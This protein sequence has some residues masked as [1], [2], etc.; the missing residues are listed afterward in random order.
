[1]S[2][3]DVTPQKPRKKEQ[4]NHPQ[5]REKAPGRP[6]RD[7]GPP[8]AVM[9]TGAGLLLPAIRTQYCF[10]LHAL[11][12]QQFVGE[13]PGGFRIDLAYAAATPSVSVAGSTLKDPLLGYIKD[14]ELL[15]GTDWV[16]VNRE[17]IIDFDSRI[18]LKL[19]TD[20]LPQARRPA[21]PCLISARLRGRGDLRKAENAAHQPLFKANDNATKVISDWRNGFD[22]GST[23][24]LKLAVTAD[25]PLEGFDDNQTRVYEE[26]RPLGASLFLGEATVKF[27]KGTCGAVNGIDLSVYEV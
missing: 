20:G 12:D 5:A 1:M 25:V 17:G 13:T 4:N 19:G 7:P 22:D 21:E 8:G 24:K 11:V 9:V 2:T 27:H 14:A 6:P 26:C 23:L 3:T 15:S 18:T 10:A 16:T